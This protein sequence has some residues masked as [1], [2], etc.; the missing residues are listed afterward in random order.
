VEGE[1]EAHQWL[2]HRNDAAGRW[3]NEQQRQQVKLIAG[4]LTEEGE[5]GVRSGMGRGEGEEAAGARN[6]RGAHRRQGI[7]GGRSWG[8]KWGWWQWIEHGG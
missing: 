4:E 5:R 2:G 3:C 7:G 1:G 6:L 8:R